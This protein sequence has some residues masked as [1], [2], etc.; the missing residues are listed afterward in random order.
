V[1]F[2]NDHLYEFVYRDQLGR[3]VRATHEVCDSPV[4]TYEVEIGTLPLKVGESMTF[5][6]DFG[7]DWR[8]NVKL[9]RIDPPGSI[10]KLPRVLESHGKAPEQYPNAE[11]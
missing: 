2:D 3:T 5:H 9:E 4:H 1:K 7:D 8:F 10:K 6:Y 11:W